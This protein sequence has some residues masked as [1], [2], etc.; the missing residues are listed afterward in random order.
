MCL[1]NFSLQFHAAQFGV[2]S[3]GSE[4]QAEEESVVVPATNCPLSQED[5]QDLVSTLDPNRH[6]M[7]FGIDIYIEVVH[8]VREM[9]SG[10]NSNN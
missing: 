10:T 3:E 9:L 5:L 4:S 7:S 6:S 1:L 2:D 8:K